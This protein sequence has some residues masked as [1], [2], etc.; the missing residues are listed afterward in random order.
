VYAHN[1]DSVGL[2]TPALTVYCTVP[3]REVRKKSPVQEPRAEQSLALSSFLLCP[4]PQPPPSLNA[5][6][7]PS[8]EP[9]ALLLVS[10]T[11]RSLLFNSPLSLSLFL[12]QGPVGAS[13]PKGD[14]VSAHV[15]H[16]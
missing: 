13:G 15:L 2:L 12:L 10:T 3:R 6:S 1:L 16:L 7:L 4:T 5:H 8:M 14:V 11:T 9:W